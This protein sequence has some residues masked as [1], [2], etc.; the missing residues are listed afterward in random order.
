MLKK[1]VKIYKKETTMEYLK[2]DNL[3]I[4]F[5]II[6][7]VNAY[8]ITKDI[9]RI[10]KTPE[11]MNEARR[12]FEQNQNREFEKPGF[13]E[14]NITSTGISLIKKKKNEK[15]TLIA[16]SKLTDLSLS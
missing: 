13:H 6:S 8:F 10:E 7:A 14:N 3:T 4:F 5:L 15:Y 9:F 12:F 11:K 16:T 2:F 1:Y